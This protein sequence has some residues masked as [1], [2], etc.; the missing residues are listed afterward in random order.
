MKLNNRDISNFIGKDIVYR[1]VSDINK[2]INRLVHN[3]LMSS[4]TFRLVL[5]NADGITHTLTI[6]LIFNWIGKKCSLTLAA[7]ITIGD[8]FPQDPL[9]DCFYK[10]GIKIR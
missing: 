8:R 3:Y 4:N 10:S 2:A 7:V 9:R 5:C 6:K 1:S